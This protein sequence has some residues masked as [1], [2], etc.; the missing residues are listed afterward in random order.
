MM[1]QEMAF[2]KNWD[3]ITPYFYAFNSNK[4]RDTS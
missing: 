3:L 4:N 2:M 1:T